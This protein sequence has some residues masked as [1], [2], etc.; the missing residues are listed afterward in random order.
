MFRVSGW[1]AAVAAVGPLLGAVVAAGQLPVAPPP[2]PAG[3]GAARQAY[4]AELAARFEPFDLTYLPRP[5]DEV[6]VVFAVRPAVVLN[7]PDLRQHAPA[8][9]AFIGQAVPFLGVRTPA[10][11]G[12]EE[13]DAL[14]IGGEPEVRLTDESFFLGGKGKGFLARTRKPY[15]WSATARR[16]F[17]GGKPVAYHGATYLAVVPDFSGA[18]STLTG[19][20]LLAG[21]VSVLAQPVKDGERYA[22]Y[23]PDGRTVVV[24]EEKAVRALID[25]VREGGAAPAPPGWDRVSRG[26][27]AVAVDNSR[28]DWVGPLPAAFP[29]EAAGPIRRVLASADALA[30]GLEIGPV[31]RV[32]LVAVGR[33]AGAGWTAT[34]AARA[35]F[36]FALDQSGRD[37]DEAVNEPDLRDVLFG[38]TV[39]PIRHGFEYVAE[40]PGDW[41]AEAVR[42]AA[43]PK[44]AVSATPPPPIPTPPASAN[45]STDPATEWSKVV[46]TP[47]DALRPVAEK[48][49]D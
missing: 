32:R 29:P 2:R 4:L 38:G 49:K 11:P 19:S 23:A 15:D 7:H 12:L 24:D 5:A 40:A 27:I 44:P 37:E 42:E 20:Q 31:N 30:V 14:I 43:T 22:V 6:R 36:A 10:G 41:I 34:A 33:D 9:N 1:W 35:F 25:R 45:R 18:V 48:K 39:R 8:V 26:L 28:K 17:P 47:L 13:V 16:W 3:L 46:P 21:V